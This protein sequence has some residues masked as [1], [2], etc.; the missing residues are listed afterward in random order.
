V[1]LT[2]SPTTLGLERAVRAGS[3]TSTRDQLFAHVIAPS[4]ADNN[5]DVRKA[6]AQLMTSWAR[7][8][9]PQLSC[10]AVSALLDHVQSSV[11]WEQRHGI[12]H[13]LYLVAQDRAL[14]ERLDSALIARTMTALTEQVRHT[15]SESKQ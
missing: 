1:S 2:V 14:V 13:A 5:I 9:S 15:H 8:V 4:I 3:L 7:V 6:A 11:Q 12:S 10:T